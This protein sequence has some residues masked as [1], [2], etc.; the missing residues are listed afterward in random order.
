MYA[1]FASGFEN[2]GSPHYRFSLEQAT[3]ICLRGRM[4]GPKAALSRRWS[5][6]FGVR[7]WPSKNLPRFIDPS[8]P[9]GRILSL[10][11]EDSAAGH[12]RVGIA[13]PPSDDEN[14]LAS[15]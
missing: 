7:V 4:P 1:R 10:R 3:K 15:S 2:S 13:G 9:Q 5:V 11:A 14:G 12:W 8:V 6:T